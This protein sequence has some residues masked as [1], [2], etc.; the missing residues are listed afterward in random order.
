MR[1]A[2]QR[3]A[4]PEKA[5]AYPF[6]YIEPLK[7]EALVNRWNVKDVPVSS[8]APIGLHKNSLESF[9]GLRSLY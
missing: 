1:R 7:N 5:A 3:R 6:S 4:T 8:M 9:P 2:P